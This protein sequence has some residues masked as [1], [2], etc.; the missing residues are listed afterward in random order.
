MILETDVAAIVHSALGVPSVPH[1][2]RDSINLSD[3]A[4][5]A[6][7]RNA[8]ASFARRGWTPVPAF[9]SEE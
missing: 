7:R 3:A 2:L 1:S 9:W 5:I 4:K 8:L 6:R